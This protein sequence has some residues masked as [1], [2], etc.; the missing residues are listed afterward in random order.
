[1]A[2]ELQNMVGYIRNRPKPG[3]GKPGKPAEV[4]LWIDPVIKM[5]QTP[6]GPVA[7]KPEDC[8]GILYGKVDDAGQ[9]TGQ[10]EVRYPE[11]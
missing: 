11:E 1:M 10:L 9:P 2:I 3:T 7:T 5:K 8:A 4:E 6:L